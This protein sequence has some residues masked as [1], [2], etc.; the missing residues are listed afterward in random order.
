MLKPIGDRIVL[1]VKKEEEK[2][3]GGLVLASSAQDKPQTAEVVAIGSGSR[4]LNGDLVPPTVKVGDLVL[5]E[6]FAGTEV[7]IEEEALLILREADILA[8]IE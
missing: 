1:R 4:T 6:K 7:K 3:V 2:N 5:F 8:I